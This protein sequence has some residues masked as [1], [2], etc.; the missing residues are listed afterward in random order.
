MSGMGG[1]SKGREGG[2][3]RIAFASEGRTVEDKISNSLAGAPYFVIAEGSPENLSVVKNS[4]K[5]LGS[6]AGEE[7][8]KI[9][10]K[11]KITILV[12]GNIGPAAARALEAGNVVVH[13]GCSGNISEAIQKCLSGKL[14]ETKGASYTGCLESPGT[15]KAKQ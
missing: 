12:T 15:A 7:A 6:A 3:C 4:A 10:L 11:E 9:L 1:K 5:G 8:A 13:A 14:I 2:P